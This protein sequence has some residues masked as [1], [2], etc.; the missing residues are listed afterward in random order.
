MFNL[1]QAMTEWRK[2]MAADGLTSSTVLEE[3]E[4]HLRDDIERRTQSAVNVQQAYH[5]AVQQLG[6]ADALTNEFAKVGETNDVLARIKH[7]LLTLAGIQNPI[8]ATNMNISS[9]NTNPEPAWATYLKSGAFLLPAVT[10]WLIVVFFIFPKFNQICH[11]AGV[12]I[13]AIYYF[14]LS[15]MQ[16]SILI[17]G[18]LVAAIALLERRSDRWPRYRRASLGVGVFALNSVVM[19]LITVMVVLAIISAT[20]LHHPVK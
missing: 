17:G 15:L 10:L 9:P 2:R 8:L 16:H 20:G 18:A 4:T 7:F 19:V 3:L 13:P 11:Q 12:A 14:V 6:H 5:E 1:E